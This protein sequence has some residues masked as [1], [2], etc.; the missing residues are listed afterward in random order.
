[1]KYH[2][3]RFHNSDT[4]R[5]V[6]QIFLFLFLF[7]FLPLLLPA[8]Q[9]PGVN[10]LHADEKMLEL[11][12]RPEVTWNRLP[13]GELF[14]QIKGGNSMREGRP[15]E[16]I[17][18][19]INI[20][21]GLPKPEGTTLEVLS[22]EYAEP[23]SGRI[24]PRPELR[25]DER[26]IYTEEWKVDESAYASY[27]P[28]FQT[29]E[30]RYQGIAR[31]LHV[32]SIVVAPVRYIAGGEK[33]EV[34]ER[35]RL[36]LRY[37]GVG[38]S[39][40]GSPKMMP[41]LHA[42]VING[43][44]ASSWI[45]PTPL[46]PALRVSA[47]QSARFWF[48]VTT[49]GEGMHAILADDFEKLGIDPRSISNIA[50]YGGRGVPLPE[51]VSK[52]Q[53]NRMNQ[54]P[55]IVERGN[56]GVSRVL[57]YAASRIDWQY[58][59]RDILDSVA[60]RVNNPYV[61]NVSYIVAVDGDASRSFPALNSP[62]SA[63]TFPSYGIGHILFEEDLVNAI[64]QGNTGN[65]GG[66]D[67]FGSGF[68]VDDFRQEATRLFT[69]EIP[70]LD[71]SYPVTYRV[72]LAQYS[73]QGAGVASVAQNG[74]PLG[75]SFPL[76]W[77]GGNY[78]TAGVVEKLFRIDA[79][80][81]A[82][83]NRSLLGITYQNDNGATAYLD[84]YE[85]HYGQKLQAID[86]RITFD[87][88][89]GT[90][91]AEYRVSGFN[92]NNLIGLDITDPANPLR[93]NPVSASGGD[94]VFRDTLSANPVVHRRYY[95]GSP[96]DA[97][98]VSN[99]T[100]VKYG[101]LRNR[102]QSTDILVVTH[103][104]F[105]PTAEQYVAYRNQKGEL[106]ASYVTTEEIYTEFSSGMLDPTAIRDY[107]SYAYHNWN[108]PPRYLILLGDGSYDYRN[109]ASSQ[110]TFV[111]IYTDGETDSFSDIYTSVYDDYY[112]RVDG[113]D[114]AV[115]LASGRF[116]VS[117]LEDAETILGKIKSYEAPRS[118]GD[119]RRKFILAADDRKPLG[120]G[121]FVSDAEVLAKEDV[122]EW[123]ETEKI[124]LPEYPTVPGVI[125]SK[126]EGTQDLLQ[127]MNR[128][129][130]LVNW[131]GHGNAKVWA[132]EEVLQKDE[133]IP[134]LT[135]DS[136]LIMVMA[137][138]CNF[139]RF[140]NPNEV[141]GGEMF[142]LRKNGGSPIVLATTRAVYIRPNSELM[143]EYVRSLF[144]R[145]E[146][147]NEFLPLGDALMKTKIANGEREND[148]KYLIFGDPSM[149]LNLPKDSVAI[150]AINTQEI[151]EDTVTVGALSLVTVEGEIY[152]RSGDL[153]EDFNGTAIVTMYD[154]DEHKIV[155]DV[156]KPTE[157]IEKGG[158][159][160]RGPAVVRN[161]KFTAQFRL[162]KDIAFDSTETASLYVY[163]YS[164]TRDAGGA[165][166]H[167]K[168]YGSDTSVVAD[169]NGP[170][171]NIYLDDRSFR[172]GD[173]VTSTPMLIVD[174]EDGSGINASGAGLGHRIEAWIGDDPNPVDLTEFY[175]TS[176]EDYR[177]GSA[178]R[179]LL[180]LEPGEYKIRV[181]AWDIFNNPSEGT[182]YFRILEGEPEALMVTDVM[183][184]PNPMGKE[185]EFLFH[186][187]QSRPLDVQLD[188][189]TAGGRKIRTLESSGVTDRFVRLP[190]DGNDRDGRHVANGVYFY[191]LRVTLVGQEGEE[192]QSVEII[193]KVAVAQ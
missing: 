192:G 50:V 69:R 84:W 131:V 153:Q 147:T 13:G 112:V 15:G 89:T 177:S 154:A 20:P 59:V 26:G 137:V 164:S 58:G 56:D 96:D 138:T 31:G 3:P 128:G 145:D 62:G 172:S 55:V 1:M 113:E 73:P 71:R 105:L 132:H 114:F 178:E 39:R 129:A 160:F 51:E 183:N 45:A 170:D 12:V 29:V 179:E 161:G 14:P 37:G 85:I 149:R 52:A 162:P 82:A 118:Y 76:R 100:S 117:T 133:F 150:S 121:E 115:D 94:F 102:N 108:K 30:L 66:R 151:T 67:W 8:Q 43:D 53:E 54:V 72:R 61:K 136:T 6:E 111:P 81:I 127:W 193:E 152:S 7:L 19:V 190:W 93:I 98:R 68:I 88:P 74:Q 90:G 47:P 168:V 110:Q 86:N 107:V 95:I 125:K 189:F 141:S 159:L 106:T 167:L 155:D 185:T 174:L 99:V 33:I 16:P 184:Y 181:R 144:Q 120:E 166:K 60:R 21:V 169:A 24:A 157:M 78:A 17:E 140:D 91:V 103:P 116:P 176:V 187:N 63:T 182:A 143:R 28:D 180:N 10:I 79:N 188:I 77:V 64:A 139:G 22:V 123:I 134:Q 46:K 146:E 25:V 126:P 87:S 36:R 158:Q 171:I 142:L 156:G 5:K 165:T 35:V 49:E 27:V 23:V 130:L 122:P 124:Y 148:Q 48:K 38:V 2:T 97:R 83:D 135:N 163:A 92:T 175:S 42:G 44:V 75:S 70:G 65:G 80:Q 186:H 11:E 40:D 34:V 119:W 4:S 101:D 18:V 9:M 32:G 104:D 57:F 109:I 191:R 41:G 173:V